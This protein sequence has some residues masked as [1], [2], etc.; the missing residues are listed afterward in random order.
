[1]IISTE[2]WFNWFDAMPIVVAMIVRLALF[3]TT[4]LKLTELLCLGLQYLP[5]GFSSSQCRISLASSCA[6]IRGISASSSLKHINLLDFGLNLS[7]PLD[8]LIITVVPFSMDV[9]RWTICVYIYLET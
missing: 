4:E 2:K 5:P 3:Q 9:A 1:M 7:Q 6:W 8:S